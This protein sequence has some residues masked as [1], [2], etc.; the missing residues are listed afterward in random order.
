MLLNILRV[1]VKRMGPDT[2]MVPSDRTRVNGHKLKHRMFRLNMRKTFTLRVT[3][4][5]N[6]FP[7]RLWILLLWRYSEPAWMRSCATCSKWSCFG[8]GVE[9]D[10]LQRSLSTPTI[11]WFC[12]PSNQLERYGLDLW[13]IKWVD[14]WLDI[15]SICS[16]CL[17]IL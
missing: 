15:G 14:N 11:L 13:P 12:D 3:E 6:R 9:L 7:G 16:S 10:D 1:T 5:W 17:F 8:K 2:A 4:H